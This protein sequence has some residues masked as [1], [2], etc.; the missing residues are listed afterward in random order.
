MDSIF[1]VTLLVA[2]Y[3][4]AVEFYVS[5]LGFELLEDTRLDESTRWIVV[6]P[7]KKGQGC[8]LV[9]AKANNPSEA[10]ALG[11]QTGNRVSFFLLTDDV[12]QD[13]KALRSHGVKFVSEP[14]THDYGTV[15]IFEDPF[16]TK[17]DLIEKPNV[18]IS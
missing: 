11:Q 13:Y 9:L 18:S 3:D 6:S 10:S 16:G 4:Q 15:A 12:G 2:D 14:I 1:Q 17:W 7:S 5:T 8:A